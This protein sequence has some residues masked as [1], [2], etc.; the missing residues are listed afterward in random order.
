M[1]ISLPV[2]SQSDV[3]W[4]KRQTPCHCPADSSPLPWHP[5]GKSLHRPRGGQPWELWGKQGGHGVAGRRALP[6][7]TVRSPQ[8]PRQAARFPLV[9]CSVLI[10]AGEDGEVPEPQPPAAQAA[11]P[12][13]L[14]TPAPQQDGAGTRGGAPAARGEPAGPRA[15]SA[16]LAPARRQPPA[17]APGAAPEGGIA[18]PLG[19]ADL[20]HQ[21]ELQQRLCELTG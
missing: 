20:P 18:G 10:A 1:E 13:A 9:T 15:A 6:H 14:P 16:A 8:R 7:S 2:G 11:Q 12:A 19:P 21:E 17:P 4:V 3:A 5:K